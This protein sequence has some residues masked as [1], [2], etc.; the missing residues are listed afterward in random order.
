[1]LWSVHPLLSL[2]SVPE[3]P[4]TVINYACEAAGYGWVNAIAYVGA[5]VAGGAL[6]WLGGEASSR[7]HASAS[8]VA[9][10]TQAAETAHAAAPGEPDAASSVSDPA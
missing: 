4:R 9:E 6:A 7:A 5:I 10:P 8:M 3:G 1:V 2:P